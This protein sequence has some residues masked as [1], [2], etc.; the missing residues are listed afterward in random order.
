MMESLDITLITSLSIVE[1]QR[2]LAWFSRQSE[3]RRIELLKKKYLVF[4][5]LEKKHKIYGMGQVLDY[6]AILLACKEPWLAS[7]KLRSQRAFMEKDYEHLNVERKTK[8]HGLLQKKKARKRE[9]LAK[10]W[11]VVVKLKTEDGL[12]FGKIAEYLQHYHQINVSRSY[13]HSYW[14]SRMG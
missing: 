13:L 12:G 6:C 14:V 2:V 1:R 11:F 4:K 9:K 5:S 3:E 10:H 7:T 8:A